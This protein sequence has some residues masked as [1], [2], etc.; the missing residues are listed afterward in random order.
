MKRIIK[1]GLLMIALIGGSIKIADAS[2]LFCFTL[3]IHCTDG[4]GSNALMCGTD[5]FEFQNEYWD[6]RDAICGGN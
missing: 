3:S 4:S 1:I 6:A 5:F 2:E